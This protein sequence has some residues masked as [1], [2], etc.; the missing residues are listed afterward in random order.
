[1]VRRP[2][3]HDGG[4]EDGA[5]WPGD[6]SGATSDGGAD[7]GGAAP[8]VVPARRDLPAESAGAGAT[9]AVPQLAPPVAIAICTFL[10]AITA[11][12]SLLQAQAVLRASGILAYSTFS[13]IFVVEVAKLLLSLGLA[14]SLEQ[15]SWPT[16]REQLL[17]AIPG[18]L[19]TF[20][21]N[22]VFIILRYL[23]AASLAV[24]WNVKIVFTALGLR[25]LVGRRLLASQWLALGVLTLGVTVSHVD[26]LW[27]VVYGCSTDAC[28][29]PRD[30]TYAIG[31]AMTLV[32]T[33]V[34]SIANVVEE[35]LL[36]DRL[37]TPLYCQNVVL[38]AWGV[39]FNVASM[40]IDARSQENVNPFKGFDGWAFSVIATQAISGIVISATFKHVSNIAAL[41]AHA[42]SMIIIAVFT[43]STTNVPFVLGMALVVSSLFGFY[44]LELRA[45]LRALLE[46]SSGSVS[47]AFTGPKRRGRAYT[48]AE[49]EEK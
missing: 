42:M 39:F 21:N 31:A 4:A 16:R 8:L 27:V 22:L 2:G 3:L 17:Y 36:K 47:S 38:Y 25:L 33:A 24:L 1:M 12:K 35:K 11:A 5:P 46:R 14:A 18:A 40:L 30:M 15:R 26:R 19:Y 7:D 45:A 37:E 43:P 28:S 9:S 29:T 41:Y 23:D 20:D 13:L 49:H 6:L 32:A 34:V 10:A 44:H 48:Q